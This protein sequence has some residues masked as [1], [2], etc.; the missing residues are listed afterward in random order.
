M[1]ATVSEMNDFYGAVI[2]GSS[3][4]ALL[5]RKWRVLIAN[6]A[7]LH[8]TNALYL[9]IPAHQ[10]DVGEAIR[11]PLHPTDK[12]LLIKGTMPAIRR[13]IHS[14][15]RIDLGTGQPSVPR[16]ALIRLDG[17]RNALLQRRQLLLGRLEMDASAGQCRRR[18][19]RKVHLRREAA[20]RQQDA[21]VGEV[22]HEGGHE[23][24][25]QREGPATDAR[26]EDVGLV[27]RDHLGEDAGDEVVDGLRVRGAVGPL[28]AGA[29]RAAPFQVL[30]RGQHRHAH[31]I[32]IYALVGEVE[33]GLAAVA[34][35]EHVHANGAWRV[36][37][38]LGTLYT[39]RRGEL[40]RGR[41]DFESNRKTAL[42]TRSVSFVFGPTILHDIVYLLDVHRHVD[43]SRPIT[44]S[45]YATR[46][47]S[48]LL[49]S[50]LF[51]TSIFALAVA[52]SITVITISITLRSRLRE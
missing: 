40:L 39:R 12:A 6:H 23:E 15:L 4:S 29:V 1:F 16:R 43:H 49:L 5:P 44:S 52:V 37:G 30:V 32:R 14:L 7:T 51:S 36:S 3:F 25:G 38:G 24:A 9:S 2:Y 41:A 22:A 10:H 20:T 50:R 11:N 13:A 31:E 35:E 47:L 45:G 21:R 34:V 26:E 48:C 8:V 18:V 19:L 17:R 46:L 28:H 42:Y 33:E 27:E